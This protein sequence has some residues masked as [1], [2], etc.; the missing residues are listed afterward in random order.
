M[1]TRTQDAG[2]FT[3]YGFAREGGYTGTKEQFEAS[4]ANAGNIPA[5]PTTSGRYT[6]VATVSNGTVTY[7]WEDFVKLWLGTTEQ[8]EDID[9]KQQDT[10]YILSDDM[11]LESIEGNLS[12]LQSDMDDIQSKSG[13]AILS[14][15]VT[16]GTGKNVSLS[17]GDYNISDFA[18]VKV[19]DI[20]CSVF[21]DPSVSAPENVRIR[22]TGNVGNLSIK[23]I[24]LLCNST[25]N[26]LVSNLSMVDSTQ[27]SISKIV[28]MA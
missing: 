1:A 12:Q 17:T 18:A 3:A 25:T 16:Y 20:I 23:N 2:I 4:L 22:G 9:P 15:T 13:M 24:D 28:G 11:A 19:D 10:V 5:P 6:L 8:Y 26:K 14:E 7:S 27:S 21:V